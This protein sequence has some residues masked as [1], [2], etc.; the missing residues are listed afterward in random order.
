VTSAHL[1]LL[2][3]LAACGGA[4]YGQDRRATPAPAP[5]TGV[6][7]L[8]TA[9]AAPIP[10]C[11]PAAATIRCDQRPAHQQAIVTTGDDKLQLSAARFSDLPGWTR[12][13]HG[14][15]LM[16]LLAS[17]ETLTAM[18]KDARVGT[19]PF[20]GKASHWLRAC[21][22]AKR[23]PVGDHKKAMR[24]FEKEFKV[25]A[26]RGS[27]GS[28]GKIT[29]YYVQPLRG[30]RTRKGRYQFPLYRRPAD[31]VSVSLSDFV[32]DGRSRR[33]WGQMNDRGTK[34]LPYPERLAYRQARSQDESHVLL[35]VDDPG[36]AIAVEIEGSGQALLDDGSVIM[37]GFAGK[38]GRKSGKL[39]SIAKAMRALSAAHGSGP[40]SQ[41][42]LARYQKIADEKTSIVFFKSDDRSGAIGSQNVVL[43]PQ[44][45][46]AVDRAV[47]S[48][49][50]P[51]W[52][53]T[54]APRSPKG[55]TA[56]YRRLLI[57]QDTGGAIVGTM[58]GDI[59][60]GHDRDAVAMGKRVNN[61][62]RMWLLL[63]RPLKVQTTPP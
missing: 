3:L 53:D 60:W 9:E 19:G 7:P 18:D 22:A 13:Q 10:Q 39:G 33:I 28:Q 29:G 55:P 5:R 57:A 44:R 17:C 51:V 40:W 31:L 45:S 21:R 32:D 6:V 63:P 23:V 34:L 50:T 8:T 11:K 43:T 16:A 14:D 61:P 1:A 56:P 35:W 41:K 46:L 36:D 27:A 15:A 24:F 38:N 42:E 26:T 37:V 2:L 48:L 62:G 30:S 20:G 58:R 54:R 4:A 12:D 49:S 47:I 59:Y 52:V 25:Y